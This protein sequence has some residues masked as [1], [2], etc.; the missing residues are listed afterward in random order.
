M[1]TKETYGIVFCEVRHICLPK[2][3][4]YIMA[5]RRKA[6][7]KKAKKRKVAK[8]KTTKKKAKKRAKKK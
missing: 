8:K 3:G 2:G 1:Y 7:K 6:A 5:K 4:D